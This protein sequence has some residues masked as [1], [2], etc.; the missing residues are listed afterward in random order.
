M[1]SKEEYEWADEIAAGWVAARPNCTEETASGLY[2]AALG[3][4]KGLTKGRE[5][6]EAAEKAAAKAK[7]DS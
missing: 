7:R 5:D 4:A 1:A 6:A 3:A 2:V